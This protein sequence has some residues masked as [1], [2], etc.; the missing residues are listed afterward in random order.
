MVEH[1]GA[2]AGR[3]AVQAQTVHGLLDERATRRPDATFIRLGEQY[4][5]FARLADDSRRCV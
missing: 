1:V 3:Q 5:T 4:V 2:M